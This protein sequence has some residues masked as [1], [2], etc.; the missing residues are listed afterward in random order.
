MLAVP[1]S[2]LQHRQFALDIDCV[3]RPIIM[4]EPQNLDRRSNLQN[5]RVQVLED[6]F[7]IT[8]HASPPRIK[9]Q[10]V[11][12]IRCSPGMRKDPKGGIWPCE[13]RV[14]LNWLC[15]VGPL[16]AESAVTAGVE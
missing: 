2:A 14:R 8:C 12:I 15:F 13:M 11:S 3:A 6:A 9:I 7:A 10:C 16:R 5:G 1:D 4:G